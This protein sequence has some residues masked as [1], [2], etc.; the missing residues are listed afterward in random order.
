MIRTNLD[1][2]WTV[3]EAGR[4]DCAAQRVDLPHDWSIHQKTRPDAPGAG[5]NGFFPGAA[6]IY[7]KELTLPQQPCR[8]LLELDGAYR[9]CEVAINGNTVAQHAYGYT[10]FFADLTQYARFGEANEIA[11]TV[12]NSALPNS[13][14]YSGTG[15]YRHVDLLL[16]PEVAIQPWGIF[17][18]TE[19]LE[20]DLAVVRVEVTVRNAGMRPASPAVRAELTNPEGSIAAAGEKRIL[21]APGEN[22]TCFLRL[23][24][25]SP[26]PWSPDDPQLYSAKVTLLDGDIPIDQDQVATGLRT[27]QVDPVRG[28]RL[29]GV[30]MKLKGGCIHHDLGPLGSAAFDQAELRRVRLMKEAGF[31]ALRC[32]H[33]PPSRGLLAACDRMGLLVIDEAFDMWTV[34]KNINDYHLDFPRDW[35]GDIDAMVLRDRAHPC[36]VLWS[37]GN[38]IPERDGTSDGAHWAGKLAERIRLLDSS[39]PITSAVNNLMPPGASPATELDADDPDRLD[40]TIRFFNDRRAR[41]FN[42]EHLLERTAA[43]TA[44]LDVVGYN[45]LDYLYDLT[46]EKFPDRV[47]CGTESFPLNIDRCWAHVMCHPQ[48]IGDFTWTSWDYLGEAGLGRSLYQDPADGDAPAPFGAPH[49][50]RTSY[51]ADFDLCGFERPQLAYRQIVWGKSQTYIASRD[52]RYHDH[53]EKIC[54]WGWPLVHHHWSWPGCEGLPTTLEV[55]SSAEEVELL[56]NGASLGRKRAGAAH[57]Y[58]AEFT[59]T[60]APGRL[61]AVSYAAGQ[62]VSRDVLETVG[63]PHHLALLPE[64]TALTA[65]GQSLCFVRVELQDRQGHR[66]P[67]AEMPLTAQVQGAATLQA[68]GTPKPDST[69]VFTSGAFTSFEGRALVILR[70]GTQA[71][72]ADLEASSPQLGTVRLTLPVLADS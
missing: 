70:A 56:L 23:T 59:L 41:S 30:S 43:Y 68:F 45:Y 14:W 19:S 61:E 7:K 72:N 26:R 33:N 66:V 46:L 31:N 18:V 53:V 44:P 9:N 36:V 40:P 2:G 11:I 60:Y 13:R 27:V 25:K 63:E 29:N 3:E 69:E 5:G 51:D 24:V 28:F 48:L 16:L 54:Q 67:T 17:P 12:N 50:W 8:A 71:G 57:R 55:Y 10:A 21:L 65:D 34:G 49:P 47:L 64:T 62:P 4:W 20:P 37:I 42:E 52:P 39:R 6:L 15:L 58:K 35:A 32:A 22:Q 1:M 38:E